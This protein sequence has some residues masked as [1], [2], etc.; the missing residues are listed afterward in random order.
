VQ[1]AAG[2]GELFVEIASQEFEH[3]LGDQPAHGD[4][5]AALHETRGQERVRQFQRS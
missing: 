2:L 1:A 3:A 5:S 4:D